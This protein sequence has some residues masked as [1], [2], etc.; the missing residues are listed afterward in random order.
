MKSLNIIENIAVLNSTDNLTKSVDIALKRFENHP[1]IIEI[2]EKVTVKA[3]FSFLKV[4]ISDIRTEIR[5]L[6][7]K[8]AG[9]F[10]NISANQLKQVEDVIVEPLMQIWNNEIIDNE[11]FPS[12]LKH[13]DITP[14]LKKLKCILKE[15]YRP[16][17]ILPVVSKILRE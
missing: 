5:N 9:T 11:K 13:A 17:S 10:L 7:T 4:E 6:D 16:V 15:N 3:K 2:K 8:K 14:I 12:A 1:S